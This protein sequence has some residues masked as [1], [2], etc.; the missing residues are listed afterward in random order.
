MG[1]NINVLWEIIC[2]SSSRSLWSRSC[3]SQAAVIRVA[4]SAMAEETAA[5]PEWPAGRDSH[6]ASAQGRRHAIVNSRDEPVRLRGVNAA[7]LEWTSNGEGH[8]L[9]T[10]KTAI[11]DW[12]VNHHSP[13]AGAGPLVRQGT[14]TEGRGQGLS[15][16]GQAGRGPLRSG[17]AATSS[18]ICTGRTRASGASRSASTSCP[19]RTAWSSGKTCASTY[20]NHPAVI[21]DLYNEPHDVS[22]DSGSK[23]ARSPRRRLERN[24][25]E[26]LRGRRDAGSARCRARHGAR[27]T[28]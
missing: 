2:D 8:I 16:A 19:T 25:A 18:S 17:R 1:H 21:F 10:V 13:A 5:K 7:C 22:W 14:R 4:R 23:A 6:A 20:K 9:E 12:H 15:R 26:D 11:R 28:S 24:P 3:V 27:R